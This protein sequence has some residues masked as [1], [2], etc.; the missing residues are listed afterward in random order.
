LLHLG[1]PDVVFAFTVTARANREDTHG[2]GFIVAQ[3]LQ[4]VSR[5]GTRNEADD[6]IGFRIWTRT[7]SIVA[8]Q[9][10]TTAAAE[11]L[12]FLFGHFAADGPGQELRHHRIRVLS[13]C[14]GLENQTIGLE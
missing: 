11:R 7:L 1:D 3:A 5:L 4:Q 2:F 14:V 10:R 13:T 9:K 12:I 8:R 6:L